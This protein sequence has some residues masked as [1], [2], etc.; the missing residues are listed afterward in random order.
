MSFITDAI[1]EL[2]IDIVQSLMNGMF[3]DVNSNLSTITDNIGKTPQEWNGNIFNMMYTI[4]QNVILPIAGLILTFVLGYEIITMITNRNNLHDVEVSNIFQY[5]FKCMI[6]IIIVSNAWSLS[7]A[8]FDL[9]KYVVQQASGVIGTS[10]TLDES[11][12]N[13]VPD[14]LDSL[15]VGRLFWL[16]IEVLLIKLVLMCISVVIT[17]ILYGRMIEIYI[18]ISVAPIPFATMSNREWG[19]IGNNYLRGLAALAFQG[20]FMLICL[21]IYSSL[22]TTA[23]WDVVSDPNGLHGLLLKV[24]GYTVVLVMTLMKCGTYSRQ[25]FSAH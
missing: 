13:N 5:V 17:V 3:S 2:E 7:N 16:I 21:G 9:G 6:A 8:I 25:I 1:K 15:G 11:L 10:A 20:F 14:F 23:V 19:Q 12:L 22:V 4:S 18:T 24:T